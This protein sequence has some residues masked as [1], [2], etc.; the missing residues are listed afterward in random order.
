MPTGLLHS[1]SLSCNWMYSRTSNTNWDNQYV[2][3][4]A[5]LSEIY[6]YIL[7]ITQPRQRVIGRRGTG[8]G[9]RH[10]R[11]S[12]SGGERGRFQRMETKESVS[13]S[14]LERHLV[15]TVANTQRHTHTA[16]LETKEQSG[17]R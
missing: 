4:I 1:F 7:K 6:K 11:G 5:L 17:I 2:M 3:Y 10:W 15:A 16:L 9:Q 14:Q 12:R 13:K 8:E